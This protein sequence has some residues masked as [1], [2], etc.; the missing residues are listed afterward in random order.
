MT[1]KKLP[2]ANTNRARAL[3][4]DSTEAERKLWSLLRS[5]RLS[6]YKFR[7]QFPIGPYI[8][9]F[10]CFAHRLVVE[11]DGGQHASAVAYDEA[12]TRCLA[13]QGWC[14]RR[15]WNNDVLANPEGVLTTILAALTNPLPSGEGAE[16]LRGG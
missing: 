9:D 14:V 16:R 15:F 1:I 6:A 10:A 12:R 5:R 2:V 11:L 13:A 8:A 3:R 4:R 7:R